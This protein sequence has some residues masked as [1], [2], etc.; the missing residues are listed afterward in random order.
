MNTVSA[1]WRWAIA[2]AVNSEHQGADILTLNDLHQ[3]TLL[4]DI[5]DSQWNI[6]VTTEGNGCGIHDVQLALDNLVIGQRLVALG[7]PDV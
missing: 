6:L 1:S 4:V 3:G 7:I 5:K 2:A